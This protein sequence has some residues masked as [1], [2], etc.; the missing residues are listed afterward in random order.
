VSFLQLP[1]VEKDT[2]NGTPGNFFGS[3]YF[4]TALVKNYLRWLES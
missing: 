2:E 3:S 4:G 1:A